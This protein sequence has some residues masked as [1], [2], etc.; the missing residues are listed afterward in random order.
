MLKSTQQNT[1]FAFGAVL[2]AVLLGIA[3]AAPNPTSFQYTVFRIVLAL[4]AAGVAAMIP[5]FLNVEVGTAIRASGAIAVFVIVY[6]FSPAAIVVTPD[7]PPP[8]KVV[9]SV[10]NPNPPVTVTVTPPA[11]YAGLG[12]SNKKYRLWISTMP[13]SEINAIDSVIY[14]HDDFDGGEKVATKTP[15]H[16]FEVFYEGGVLSGTV[17]AKINWNNRPRE[18]LNFKMRE[19][20][21]FQ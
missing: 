4:A 11:G 20:G 14:E 7:L 12:D 2:I 17:T 16:G 18:N 10:T 19:V 1:A 8:P 9:D 15:N 13:E 3:F 21:E 6:F 5:G